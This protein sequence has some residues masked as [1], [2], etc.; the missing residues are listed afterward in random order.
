MADLKDGEGKVEKDSK[1][2][3]VKHFKASSKIGVSGYG[4]IGPNNNIQSVS[5]KT[6]L[7]NFSVTE[8]LDLFGRIFENVSITRSEIEEVFEIACNDGF[9][10]PAM[11]YQNEVRYEIADPRLDKFISDFNFLYLL[12]MHKL[13]PIWYYRR[14]PYT[15]EIKWLE[16]FR[17]Q[18]KTKEILSETY[19]H[20]H[21]QSKTERAENVRWIKQVVRMWDIRINNYLTIMQGKH[22]EMIRQYRFPTEKIFDITYQNSYK[23]SSDVF[24]IS[25]VTIIEFLWLP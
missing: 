17:G 5:F 16:L 2:F 25:V 10:R 11:K 4:E 15:Q 19:K 18:Q 23:K 7:T 12:I 14:A 8:M 6:D 3:I 24:E 21:S 1:H 22:M 13:Y 20:R 9:L